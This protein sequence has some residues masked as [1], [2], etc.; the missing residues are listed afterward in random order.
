[1]YI[2]INSGEAVTSKEE[3][4]TCYVSVNG[5]G[6]YPHY[7]G[8]AKIRGRGNSTWE[9]YD[10][11]PYRI[12]LD[13]KASILGLEANK[14]W[15]LLANYRDVTDLMNTFVFEAGHFLDMPCTNHTRYTEVFLN[16]EY[17]GLFIESTKK[18]LYSRCITST[19]PYRFCTQTLFL[20]IKNGAFIVEQEKISY[21][22]NPNTLF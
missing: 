13:K 10:K 4:V 5:R 1:M 6:S 7:S 20:S 12:K 14:D 2:T 16:G 22:C 8:K 3:Y 21:I 19:Q 17:I 9:W 15:V 18:F 11:K